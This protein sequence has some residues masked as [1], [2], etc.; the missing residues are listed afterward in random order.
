VLFDLAKRE[1]DRLAD[2]LQ[3]LRHQP[4]RVAVAAD[5]AVTEALGERPSDPM[6][7]WRHELDPKRAETGREHRNGNHQTPTQAAFLGHDPHQCLVADDVWPA[8]VE[9]LAHGLRDPEAIDQV[10]EHVADRYRLGFRRHP[11]WRDHHGQ[12]LD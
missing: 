11:L 3:P 5:H 4:R 12:P 1:A 7:Q 2:T 6:A 8:N 10:C 9:R